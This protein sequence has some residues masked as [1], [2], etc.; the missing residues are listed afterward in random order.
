MRVPRSVLERYVGVYEYIPSQMSRTDLR[1]VIGL[2]GDTLTREM[3]REEMLTPISETRFRVGSTSLLV[4]FV[5]DEA[6]GRRSWARAASR[7]W[8]A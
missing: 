5:V 8:P 6:G 3:G 7:C 4:E 1:I 2:K